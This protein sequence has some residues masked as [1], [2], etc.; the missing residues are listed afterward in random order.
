VGD[1]GS[2]S[3][4]CSDGCGAAPAKAR[5]ARSPRLKWP[6]DGAFAGRIG[7]HGAA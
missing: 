4:R 3:I 7:W 5:T 1:D 6:V 2:R